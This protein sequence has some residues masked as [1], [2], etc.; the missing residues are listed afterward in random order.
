MWR[1]LEEFLGIHLLLWIN[2][3]GGRHENKKGK[4][5]SPYVNQ[6]LHIMREMVSWRAKMGWPCM[7]QRASQTFRSGK[8]VAK[9]QIKH[10]RGG[11]SQG[12]HTRGGQGQE[13]YGL[14]SKAK[15]RG[16]QDQLEYPQTP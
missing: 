13:D 2:L 5:S 15:L 11:E 1:G 7:F 9:T 4:C 10:T 8:N 14:G 12:E 3:E 6:S 16:G